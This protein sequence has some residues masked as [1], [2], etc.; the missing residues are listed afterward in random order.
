MKSYSI[1]SVSTA[2]ACAIAGL[3]LIGSQLQAADPASTLSSADETFVK[4]A[5]QHGLGEVQIAAL[6]V[7]KA[8]R[9]D[10]KELAEKLV[11]EHT[12]ANSDLTA[13]SQTKKVAISAV[14]DP[15]DTEKLKALEGKQTG[16]EFD[17]AFLNQLERD[18]KAAIALF[19]DA[20][21]DSKDDQVKAWAGKTLPT[22]RAHLDHVQAALKK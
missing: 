20:S 22:L 3:A 16:D 7:K 9:P 15:K 19:E 13:L 10:V 18:H 14:T 21:K 11:T 12:A 2:F 6:G 1:K 4:T 5:S 8:S 17:K